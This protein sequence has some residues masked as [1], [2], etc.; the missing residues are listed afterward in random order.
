MFEK[1]LDLNKL[2]GVMDICI[3]LSL[4][5]VNKK[6]EEL[7]DLYCKVITSEQTADVDI[8]HPQYATMA[9]YMACK[10]CKQK[11]AKTKLMPFSN[12]RPTQWQQLEQR[13]EKFIAKHYN[14]AMDNKLKKQDSADLTDKDGELASKIKNGDRKMR[15]ET[16]DYDKWKKRILAMAEAKLNE[17]QDK[18]TSEKAAVQDT[19]V[20]FSDVINDMI[21]GHV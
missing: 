12:L 13:W 6:A 15:I 16:E 1:L 5:Q 20:D 17:E 10:L 11:V 2:V 8:S 9:V 21:L 19:D 18:A 14:D 4:N 3:Q 7:L